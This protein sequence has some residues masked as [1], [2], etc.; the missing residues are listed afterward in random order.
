MIIDDIISVL[1][2]LPYPITQAK[3]DPYTLGQETLP[4]INIKTLSEDLE[5]FG[6]L[7]DFLIKT[8]IGIGVF[9][10]ENENYYADIRTIVELILT[11]LY[12]NAN[13][14]SLYRFIPDAKISYEYVDGGETNFAAAYINLS[15]QTTIHYEPVFTNSLT[16]INISID[17][18]LPFDQSIATNGPDGQIE[19]SQTITLPT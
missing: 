6:N 7:P 5:H 15:I 17:D 12:T 8:N 4:A 1:S 14:I 11:T 16:T 3:V 19:I 18:G 2:V 9:V 13:W 10:A